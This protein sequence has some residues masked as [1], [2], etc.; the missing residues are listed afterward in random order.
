MRR[1]L[2]ALIFALGLSGASAPAGAQGT[3]RIALGT[4]LSQLDPAKT[5]IGDEYV[6][7]HLVF[8]GL[9]RIDPDMSVKPDLAESW[10]ASDDLKTW[11]FKLRQGVKFHDG[12]PF[13]AQAF[14][15][16]FDRQKDPANKCRCAFYITNVREVQAP[17]E[18]TV[19]YNLTDPS[20]NLPATNT[21][22]SQNN[23]VHSPT[24][25][26][27]KG[28]DYNRNPVGTGPYILKS[29]TAGDRMVLE[30]NPNYWDKGRPY[31]DVSS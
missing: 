29:W 25:W 11:T 14:K 31:L 4:T 10:T 22:Q 19:V 5:T 28:D 3:I 23:V 12:T 20:V 27:T 30:K 21:I 9:S 7:V 26:K 6:Y 15:E 17:D 16:N 13:N 1:F 8:N 2:S 24:A 18:Y